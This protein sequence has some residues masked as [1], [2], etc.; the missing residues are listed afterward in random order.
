MV[1]EYLKT[2]SEQMEEYYEQVGRDKTSK[3]EEKIATKAEVTGCGEFIS[4]I[5]SSYNFFFDI[6]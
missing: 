5:F 2:T 3:E 1:A 6:Y 4:D